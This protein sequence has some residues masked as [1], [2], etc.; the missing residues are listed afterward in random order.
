MTLGNPVQKKPTR[1]D[2]VVRDIH[3]HL[4]YYDLDLLVGMNIAPIL[5]KE[6]RMV[7]RSLFKGRCWTLE[8]RL[9]ASAI[10]R[11]VTQADSD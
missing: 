2:Q 11:K 3:C 8:A 1:G 7:L 6:T 4:M 5:I 9:F 10:S